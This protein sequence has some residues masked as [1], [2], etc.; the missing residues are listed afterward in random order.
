M[1]AIRI[2]YSSTV[3]RQNKALSLANCVAGEQR[4]TLL[5]TGRALSKGRK[6]SSTDVHNFRNS[7]KDALTP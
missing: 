3:G 5:S 6:V 7:M 4:K 1:F 2:D